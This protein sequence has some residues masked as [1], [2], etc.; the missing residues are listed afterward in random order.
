M[1]LRLP[2]STA[3]APLILCIG[4]H[5]DDIEIGCGG[6]LAAI[7][8]AY[9]ATR[10]VFWVFSGDSTR[11]Q[12]SKACLE[13]LTKHSEL[14]FEAFDQPDSYFPA[15][16]TA[17][18]KAMHEHGKSLTPDI[19][20][21]HATGDAHQDHRTL[22]ELTWNVFRNHWIL[23]YEIPKYDGDLRQPNVFIP[24]S[25]TLIEQK[26]DALMT[27]FASQS[28][29]AWFTAETFRAIARLRGIECNSNSGFAEGFYGRKT[30]LE[31]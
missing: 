4:A 17:I 24:L 8:Q 15:H 9:P 6:T 1:M 19:I 11:T 22:A 21:T 23:E 31:L 7:A 25:E 26:I 2:L 12:E 5:C 16:W 30:V 20:F 18:K 29:R 27:A 14:T 3:P 13:M 10:F 28:Q